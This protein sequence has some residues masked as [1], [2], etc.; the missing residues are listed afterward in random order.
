MNVFVALCVLERGDNSALTFSV[1]Y[2]GLVYLRTHPVIA[3]QNV[4][5]YGKTDVAAGLWNVLYTLVF[6]YVQNK[7]K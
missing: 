4:V 2:P 1:V 6:M 5:L 3:I 7:I